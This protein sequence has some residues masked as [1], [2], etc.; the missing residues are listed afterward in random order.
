MQYPLPSTSF[1]AGLDVEKL[2]KSLHILEPLLLTS[3]HWAHSDLVQGLRIL[4]SEMGVADTKKLEESYRR[5]GYNSINHFIGSVALK[6]RVM[7]SHCQNKHD[8]YIAL[9]HSGGSVTPRGPPS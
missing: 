5:H 2:V 3:K 6:L 4:Q 9:D 7:M 1:K 8:Q